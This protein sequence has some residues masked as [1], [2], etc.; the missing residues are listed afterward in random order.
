MGK[1]RNCLPVRLS[2]QV[3]GLARS[4]IRGQLPAERRQSGLGGLG[5]WPVDGEVSHKHDRV[6][7]HGQVKH[8]RAF[9]TDRAASCRRM[10][11]R[12]R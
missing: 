2:V 7:E 1:P 4:W 11:P 10:Y 12:V 9:S 8:D 3:T 6:T 5:T